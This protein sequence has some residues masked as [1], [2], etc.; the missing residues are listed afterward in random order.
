[1]TIIFSARYQS[2]NQTLVQKWA[3]K[4]ANTYV[5][6]SEFGASIHKNS[7]VLWHVCIIYV[8]FTISRFLKYMFKWFSSDNKFIRWLI[9]NKPKW[10]SSSHPW[11][12]ANNYAAMS[13]LSTRDNIVLYSWHVLCT[14]PSSSS[15][16]ALTCA[17]LRKNV[18][19]FYEVQ[20]Y[21][22]FQRKIFRAASHTLTIKSDNL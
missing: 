17:Q 12:L 8:N 13:W 14:T 11:K 6:L 15:I 3:Q 5:Y 10:R 22:S 7:V 1:M 2:L 21:N 18:T 16:A 9:L 20:S 4:A 19:L